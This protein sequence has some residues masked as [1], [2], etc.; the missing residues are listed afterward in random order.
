MPYTVVYVLEIVVLLATLVALVP[1]VR[2][3][4]ASREVDS[5]RSF[6]LADIPA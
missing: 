4:A 1:L 3:R 5:T 6:G 2:R